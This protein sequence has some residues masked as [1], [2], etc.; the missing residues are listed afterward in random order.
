MIKLLLPIICCFLLV[1]CSNENKKKTDKTSTDSITQSIL[2]DS[3]IPNTVNDKILGKTDS[4]NSKTQNK[5]TLGVDGQNLLAF[6][7]AGLEK[8]KQQNYKEAIVQF[9]KVIESDPANFHSYF[10]RGLSKYRLKEYIG[11]IK[12][13][14]KSIKIDPKSFEAYKNRADAKTYIQDLTGSIKDYDKSIELNPKFKD[15][16][17]NRGMVKLMLKQDDAACLDLQKASEL[18]DTEVSDLIKQYCK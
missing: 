16:Y 14:N 13:F 6:F 17:K 4:N 5:A 7:N 8:F 2:P 12:D 18:G 9:S 3:N 10:N 11:A 15:A 1:Q